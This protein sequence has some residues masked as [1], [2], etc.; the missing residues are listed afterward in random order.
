LLLGLEG[1]R[2]WD[3]R[4][5][6]PAG[7]ITSVIRVE[8]VL[9]AAGRAREDQIIQLEA[10]PVPTAAEPTGGEALVVARLGRRG[11]EQ[12]ER[13][14]EIVEGRHGSTGGPKAMVSKHKPG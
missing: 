6:G 10:V 1:L 3:G 4:A 5:T 12:R 14:A 13:D 9:G 11:L 2:E 8:A 7:R